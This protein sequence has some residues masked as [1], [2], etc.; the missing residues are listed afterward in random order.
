MRVLRLSLGFIAA[1]L[2]TAAGFAAADLWLDHG[3]L[4]ILALGQEELIKSCSASLTGRLAQKGFHMVTVETD[5]ELSA[6]VN[7]RPMSPVSMARTSSSRTS[8]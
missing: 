8:R 4:V 6:V 1:V 3:R 5:V 7:A 2:L